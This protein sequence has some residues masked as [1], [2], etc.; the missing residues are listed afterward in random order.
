VAT[1]AR[2]DS[3]TACDFSIG[4]AAQQFFQIAIKAFI[5]V[6]GGTFKA[7]FQ[8]GVAFRARFQ[9]EDSRQK[10][11]FSKTLIICPKSGGLPAPWPLLF[12]RNWTRREKA[13]YFPGRALSCRKDGGKG[14]KRHRS[15]LFFYDHAFRPRI[16]ESQRQ[17]HRY[18]PIVAEKAAR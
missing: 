5:F 8:G 18:L 3:S 11:K 9:E 17:F 13:F 7:A 1:W 14:I 12:S 10:I 2:P 16:E 15:L 6:A 4:K